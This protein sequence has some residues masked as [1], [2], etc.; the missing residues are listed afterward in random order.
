[1]CVFTLEMKT[2]VNGFS[3]SKDL[4]AE[5]REG[6]ILKIYLLIFFINFLKISLGNR[7]GL[8]AEY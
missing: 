1:M 6:K 4:G 8:L 2:T 3:T 7:P 5:L